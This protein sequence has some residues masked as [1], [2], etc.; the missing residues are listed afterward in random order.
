MFGFKEKLMKYFKTYI[1]AEYSFITHTLYT[2]V[3]HII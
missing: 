2:Y 1:T 3:Y